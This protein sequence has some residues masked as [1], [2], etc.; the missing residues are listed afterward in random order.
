MRGVGRRS[1]RCTQSVTLIGALHDG[2]LLEYTGP[3]L[4][5]D[6][7]HPET[8]LTLPLYGLDQLTSINSWFCSKI[9]TLVSLPENG[10]VQWPPGTRKLQCDRSPS[11][12]W[13]LGVGHWDK[14]RPSEIRGVLFILRRDGGQSA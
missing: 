12:H 1:Q 5:D 7:S 4:E 2:G 8:A 11:G 13:L 6:P 9:G 14:V 10:V 3:V